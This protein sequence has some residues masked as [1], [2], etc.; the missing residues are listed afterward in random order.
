MQYSLAR[1]LSAYLET[2]SRRIAERQGALPAC[3]Q[4]DPIS[5]MILSLIGART[6]GEVSLKVF[7]GLRERFAD[8]RDIFGISEAALSRLIHPVTYPE[9]KAAHLRATLR[10]IEERGGS[11]HLDFLDAWSVEDAQAW[12]RKLPGV[13]PK[14]S[15]A[16]L[17]FSTLRKRVLVV[18]CHHFRVAKRLGLLRPHTPF[19]AAQRVLMNQHVPDGWGADDLDDHHRHM[20]WLGQTLCPH[21]GA[22]CW[23]CPLQDLCPA[24][25]EGRRWDP[26]NDDFPDGAYGSDERFKA[27]EAA[28]RQPLVASHQAEPCPIPSQTVE[29]CFEP[30]A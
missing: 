16:I 11:L 7:L 20:K 5:Q 6:Q 29:P 26:E 28:L 1:E 25:R 13:G 15:A 9:R 8:W 24:G 19:A 27:S 14:V 10:I 17:N 18:D 22:L 23:K 2:I 3:V 12:L 4:L 21:K 30:S